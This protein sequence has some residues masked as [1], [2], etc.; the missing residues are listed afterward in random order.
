MQHI[1]TNFNDFFTFLDKLYDDK[2][3]KIFDVSINNETQLNILDTDSND[4]YSYTFEY[5]EIKD[6]FNNIFNI[7]TSIL[8]S[9]T[10]GYAF[11]ISKDIWKLFLTSIDELHNKNELYHKFY[12]LKKNGKKREIIAPSEKI[13]PYLQSINKF[14]QTAYDY[15]NNSFQVAYKKN[16]N[17]I[18]NAILHKDNNYIFKIDLKDFFPSCKRDY[19]RKYISFLFSSCPNNTFL[20]EKFLDLILYNDGLF[21]GNPVSGTLANVIISSPVLYIKFMCDKMNINFS[22]YADDMT[23]SSSRFISKDMILNIFNKAFLYYNMDKDFVLNTDK[24]Y[25]LSNSNR[26]IT[27]VAINNKDQLT[28][29]RR[30]YNR[31]RQTLYQLNNNDKSHIV[32]KNK[33]KNKDPESYWTLEQLKGNIAYCLMVD[34]S[35]KIVKL[36]SKYSSVVK[37]Y[38]LLSQETC[39]KYNI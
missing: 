38:K 36:L 22:V 24:C 35:G 29:R 13:K 26:F 19:V 30:K 2:I 6:F 18:N 23:F 12:I 5:D 16:K 17:V 20:I 9:N 39:L 10:N 28:C 33:I 14:F 8:V 4:T 37:K 15:K 7:K 34:Y 1:I 21:I 32:S 25:G 31:I 3:T 11:F 27:G